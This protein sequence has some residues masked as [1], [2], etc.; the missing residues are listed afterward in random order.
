MGYDLATAAQGAGWDGSSV[1]EVLCTIN[2]G[3]TIGASTTSTKAFT[4]DGSFPSGSIL[5]IINKGSIRG[6]GG[7]GGSVQ[8]SGGDGTVEHNAVVV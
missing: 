2:S 7:N 1:C 5:R 6:K 4:I 8:A 3:V